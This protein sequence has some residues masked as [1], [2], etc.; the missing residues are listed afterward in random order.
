MHSFHYNYIKKKINRKAKLLF[1][2]T[3]NITYEIEANNVYEHFHKNKG[4]IDFGEYPE[5][6]KLYDKTNKRTMGK[7]KDKIIFSYC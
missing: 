7:I 4:K 3:D 2:D 5:N 6:L 1:T